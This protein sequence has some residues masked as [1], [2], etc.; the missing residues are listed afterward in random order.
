[1]QVSDSNSCYASASVHVEVL[2]SPWA[3]AGKDTAFCAGGTAVLT[4]SGGKHYL[5]NTTETTASIKVTPANTS[6]Y[7]VFVR[8]SNVCITE[9]SVLVTVHPIP[10]ADAGAG[11]NGCIGQST[12]LTAS[13]GDYY[14]WNTGDS[15]ATI[16]F[17]ASVS[18]YYR[19][20]VKSIYGCEAND[21]VLLSVWPV[22]T[23]GFEGSPLSGIVPLQTTFIDSSHISSGNIVQYF[24]D[25]GDTYTASGTFAQHIYTVAG[26]YDVRLVAI[27]D[28]NCPDTVLKLK[29]VEALPSGI[30]ENKNGQNIVISP[31]PAKTQTTVQTNMDGGMIS[32]IRMTDVYGREIISMKNLHSATVNLNSV[33]KGIFYLEIRL[34]TGSVIFKKLVFE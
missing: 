21:S 29:Y 19:V 33:A 26:N 22:P 3:D 6:Y 14:H 15:T 27:S 5:W 25:F 1:M 2:P 23:A 4:A 12:T 32:S 13:G 16:H 30:E 10:L 20:N 17:I 11:K 18:A 8:D 34:E 31:N 7:K 24:W 28:K 9:D